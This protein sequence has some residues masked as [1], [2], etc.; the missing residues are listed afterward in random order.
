MSPTGNRLDP[1]QMAHVAHHEPASYRS[2]AGYRP[3]L[4]VHVIV[5]CL[6]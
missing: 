5:I 2:S 1:D 6:R 4:S 3:A